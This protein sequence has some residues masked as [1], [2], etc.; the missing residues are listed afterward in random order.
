MY[1]TNLPVNYNMHCFE[2]KL[3]KRKYLHS[4]IE[5]SPNR[6]HIIYINIGNV[7]F[8]I[9]KTQFEVGILRAVM[10]E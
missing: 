9:R 1:V 4:L 2:E 10:N 5:R 6:K 7:I 8:S 3:K